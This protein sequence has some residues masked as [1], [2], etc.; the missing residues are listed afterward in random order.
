MQQYGQPWG[1]L[2]EMRPRTGRRRSPVAP[3]R[4]E[5]PFCPKR[6]R[7]GSTQ[8]K[9][10]LRKNPRSSAPWVTM[11]EKHLVITS[12]RGAPSMPPHAGLAQSGPTCRNGWDALTCTVCHTSR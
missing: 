6:H 11:A 5:G 3:R 4:R 2:P 9:T 1:P 7:F 10:F 12:R 8:T